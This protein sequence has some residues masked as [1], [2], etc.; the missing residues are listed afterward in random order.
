MNLAFRL[1]QSTASRPDLPA[2]L[3]V[4]PCRST[5]L[6]WCPDGTVEIRS[7]KVEIGQGILTALGQIAA[8]ELRLPIERIR[9]I[10]VQ[11]GVSPDEAVTSGSL[12]I[13]ESGT[14][15]RIVCAELRERLIARAAERWGIAAVA[16][17]ARDG[18]VTGP[19]DN[20][21]DYRDLDPAS[22][23]EGEVGAIASAAANPS[24]HLPTP[25]IGQSIPRHDLPAKIRGAPAYL[26][27]QRLPG[28]LHA[29]VVRAA[30]PGATLQSVSADALS[31]FG[32][33]VRLIRDGNFLAVV[34]EREWLAIRAAEHLVAATRWQQPG[35]PFDDQA[36]ADWL[37]TQPAESRVIAEHAPET[38]ALESSAI[39]TG[40]IGGGT[41]PAQSDPDAPTY[42]AVFTK[43]F[44][45]H[46]SLMPSCALARW[47][48]QRLDI[49]THSQGPYNLRADLAL[50]FPDADI[51]VHHA[52]GAGC[53]G[54]NAADDVALDA[55]LIARACGAPVRVLW[56]RR[57]ELIR[58]PLGSAMAMRVRA[59]MQGGHITRWEHEVWSAGHS[60]R[61]GRA[62][63]PTLLA[64]TEIA[65]NRF[66]PRESVNAALAAGGG[67]ERNAIPAY[68][69]NAMRIVNHR[70]RNMPLRTSALRSLGAF[71]NVFALESAI[72]DLAELAHQDPIAF[73]LAHLDHPR[74]RR[75]LETLA[76]R[77]GATRPRHEMTDTVTG[78]GI[79]FA[80]YKNSGAWCAVAA[81]I[82]VGESI[83]VGKLTVVADLGEVINPD[84]ARNQL[85]G[86]AIQACSWTLLET[87]RIDRAEGPLCTDWSAYPILNFSSQ[88]RVD[89]VL[90]EAANE[91][92]L[93]AGECAHGPTAAAIG[94]ALKQALGIRVKDLPLTRER[95]MA[96]INA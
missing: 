4:N 33:S 25:I 19:N 62:P 63:T 49:W 78:T 2:S 44:I 43:P 51:V 73:R 13:Q 10:P 96:A 36:V 58:A 16:C 75:V 80:H 65:S 27:D 1:T 5:W 88:P 61:P 38:S 35:L 90:I 6:G 47:T 12:S 29:R 69:F 26:H 71:G 37:R 68:R 30:I 54:H 14:A 83:T 79:G 15:I 31:S 21:L 91:P 84:G 32:N 53:Y 45:A 76:A 92:P 7:G 23:L 28:L 50:V 85:E 70:V 56:S 20:R 55:A 48:G 59:W 67:S 72:D 24:A 81:D 87:M 77:R 41:S 8:H 95:L 94:N 17:I 66:E 60:L 57:D 52:E 86:G 46:A 74:A 82:E 18:L 39:P 9:M 89:V 22:L 93:G 40:K 42:E 34:A 3:A 11:T 64:A